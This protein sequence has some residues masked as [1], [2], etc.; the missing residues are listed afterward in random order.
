MIINFRKH[1]TTHKRK[2]LKKS[3]REALKTVLICVV[4]SVLIAALFFGAA[5]QA[6]ERMAIM[7]SSEVAR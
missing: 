2:R 1:H 3:I 7:A 5:F 4:G 6:Q